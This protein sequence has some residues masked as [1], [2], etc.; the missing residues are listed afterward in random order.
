M[1]GVPVGIISA[2]RQYSFLDYFV[3]VVGMISVSIPAFFLALVLIYFFALRLDW[4]PATGMFTVGQERTFKVLTGSVTRLAAEHPDGLHGLYLVPG[5]LPTTR[6]SAVPNIAGQEKAGIVFDGTPLVSGRDEQAAYTPRVQVLKEF[7][8]NYVTNGS[9]DVAMVRMEKEA[10]AQ[11]VDNS[12]IVYHCSI[13]CY[14][15]SMLDQGGFLWSHWCGSDACEER[16]K[17]ETKATIRCIPTSRK[18]ESGAC[19]VCGSSS[20]G[21]VIFARAY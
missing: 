4:L 16:V 2:V 9:N 19:V 15:N 12:T 8:G 7:G 13:A 3:T 6:Q 21:R 18:E 5:D 11:G 20:E 1:I 17:N 10:A 14:T